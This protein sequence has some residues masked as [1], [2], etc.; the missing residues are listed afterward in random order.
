MVGFAI[1][2]YESA[3][4]IHVHLHTSMAESCLSLGK[5]T[6]LSESIFF[7]LFFFMVWGGNLC[8][9]DLT[10]YFMIVERIK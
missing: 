9:H 4:G 8:N 1:H 5:L 3:M 10:F 7:S 6:D 2:R